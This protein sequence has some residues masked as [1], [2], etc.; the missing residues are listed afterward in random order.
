MRINK[1]LAQSGLASRRKCDEFIQQGLIKINGKVINDFS[2]QVTFDD[3]VYYKNKLVELIVEK[4]YYILYKPR[5]Y[6]CSYN[7]P[8]NRKNIYS[9]LPNDIRI[10]SVGRLDYDTT[11][12]IFVTNDGDFTNFLCH[13]KYNVK[14]KYVVH[15]NGKLT[16]TAIKDLKK[17]I[18]LDG[19]DKVKAE[20][21]YKGYEKNKYVWDVHLTEG[22]NR[23]IKRIFS[24]Y[25][26][27]VTRLHRYEFAGLRLNKIKEGKYKLLKK[28]IIET[29]KVKYG[30][31]K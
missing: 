20:I 11:G 13:P 9:L 5:G 15:S 16:K 2:Y 27:K 25:N 23:E 4:K 8:N 31:K 6:I 17:G 12:L 7:D 19:K 29:I 24:S 10:F 18:L 22:K 30:Y 3:I 26:I 14:K 1:Y 21:F 28:N